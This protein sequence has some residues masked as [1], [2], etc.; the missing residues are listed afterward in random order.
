MIGQVMIFAAT[1]RGDGTKRPL[2]TPEREPVAYDTPYDVVR[3]AVPNQPGS[4]LTCRLLGEHEQ[5]RYDP[6]DSLNDDPLSWGSDGLERLLR[7]PPERL[8]RLATHPALPARWLTTLYN[9]GWHPLQAHVAVNPNM[10][11]GMFVDVITYDYPTLA[12]SNGLLDLLLLEN[13][14][15]LDEMG[16]HVQLPFHL[17]VRKV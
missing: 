4:T 14:V 5:W 15:L 3:V 7:Q 17:G 12:L 6:P 11:R 9:L 2:S 16:P 8:L 13:P 1:S 10:D